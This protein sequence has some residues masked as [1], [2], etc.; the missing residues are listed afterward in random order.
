MCEKLIM[1]FFFCLTEYVDAFQFNHGPVNGSKKLSDATKNPEDSAVLTGNMSD[2]PIS[3][4]NARSFPLF[5][6][7][8]THGFQKRNSPSNFILFI[9]FR[10]ASSLLSFIY[11]SFSWSFIFSV[12]IYLVHI[13][14]FCVHERNSKLGDSQTNRVRWAECVC[15]PLIF[16]SYLIKIWFN[17]DCFYS[18]IGK[19][20][21]NERLLVYLTRISPQRFHLHYIL[22]M[23]KKIYVKKISLFV[24]QSKK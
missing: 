23:K 11:F 5:T 10:T 18:S 6:P 3:N 12:S 7:P 22:F 2:K 17:I 20:K 15:W 14:V 4:V 19:S 9:N 1:F 24:W 13:F 21:Q 8:P 16:I